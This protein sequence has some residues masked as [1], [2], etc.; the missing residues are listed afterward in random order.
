MKVLGLPKPV[1]YTIF[2][3]TIIKRGKTQKK[4]NNI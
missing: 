1:I 3:K 2:H 4:N